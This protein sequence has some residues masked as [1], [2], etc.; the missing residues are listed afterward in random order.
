MAGVVQS[1]VQVLGHAAI[2]DEINARLSGGQYRTFRFAVAFAR[3]SG[4]HLIDEQ[5]RAFARE[6]GNRIDGFVGV[7]L[8]GTTIEALTY[9]SELPNTRL[10]VV[11]SG[12]SH[13][14]F[15]PK[16]YAFEG[17]EEWAAIVGSSNLT[18]GGLYSNIESFLVIQGNP[19]DGAVLEALFV[20]YETA[21]FSDAN[22]RDV[23]AS[24][25]RE[26]AADL[27]HYTTDPPDRQQP[28][29][30]SPPPLDPDFVSPRPPGRPPEQPPEGR[31]AA[32]GSPPAAPVVV[33]V[34]SEQ[35]YMELWDETGGGTQVQIAKRVFL[36]FFGA[37]DTATTY[38]TLDT[39]E[40]RITGLRLQAFDNV[41]YRIG[42]PF[43]GN[44]PAQSGRRGV[45]RFTRTAPDHYR[46]EQRLQGDPEYSAWR[47][48]CDT[49]TVDRHKHWGIH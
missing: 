48:R 15:H 28:G 5:L 40:G 26:I 31:K 42:L 24:L 22:V 46:V 8:G 11:R 43:V 39:P 4:L 7:D 18:T 49:E 20:P 44:S 21:P 1:G 25:L 38:I 45:L 33:P 2:A 27:D 32:P 47:S 41:T 9:L 12:M 37:S 35:L 16:V 13:V 19:T 29:T 14:V 34:A 6:P 30:S 23:D 36:E 17:P 3:W 10:R